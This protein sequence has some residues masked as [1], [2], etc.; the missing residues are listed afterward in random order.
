MVQ[1]RTM[2]ASI[3]QKTHNPPLNKCL[4]LVLPAELR[5]RIYEL[6]IPPKSTSGLVVKALGISKPGR[7]TISRSNIPIAL[8]F[9]C[10][11][12]KD[13]VMTIYCKSNAFKFGHGTTDYIR[14]TTQITPIR[15]ADEICPWWIGDHIRVMR[16]IRVWTCG[17]LF[18]QIDV[19]T[20]LSTSTVQLVTGDGTPRSIHNSPAV[21]KFHDKLR[22]TILDF[23][24]DVTLEARTLGIEAVL[25][26]D[27]LTELLVSMDNVREK[28]RCAYHD[29][30][31]AM[32]ERL[33]LDRSNQLCRMRSRG[34]RLFGWRK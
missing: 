27:N 5:V 18:F 11:Q 25:D 6:L 10:R 32:E 4:L 22:T 19:G 23:L 21:E 14:L 12:I 13:E 31:A 24:K 2:R 26:K 3:L 30:R 20:S 8:I 28:E 33:R 17:E 9:T 29:E 34:H 15:N 1:T 16:N 7:K